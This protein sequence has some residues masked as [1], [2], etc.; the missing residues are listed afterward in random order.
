MALS[1]IADSK[2]LTP[3]IKSRVRAEV[4]KGGLLYPAAH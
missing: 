3:D 4:A 2:R 1:R